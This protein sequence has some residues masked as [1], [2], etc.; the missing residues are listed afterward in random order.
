MPDLVERYAG[1]GLAPW[2]AGRSATALSM[3]VIGDRPTVPSDELFQRA[4]LAD[5]NVVKVALDTR[6]IEMPDG[7]VIE[8]IEVPDVVATMRTK[9][10]TYLG[11]VSPVY[12]VVQN[13]AMKVLGDAIMGDGAL[14][15]TAGSLLGGRVAWM[16][17][18]IDGQTV[19][20]KGDTSPTDIYFLIRT[21]HDA[22]HA[23][24]GCV[25]PI[26]TVCWN[27]MNAAMESASASIY[28]R[29]TSGIES[30][31]DELAKEAKRALGIIPKAVERFT[32]DMN[33]L[34]EKPMTID[35]FVAFTKVFLPV[36]PEVEKPVRIEA[37]QRQLLGVFE[38][39]KL[40]DGL[41]FTAYRAFNA[42]TEW[43]DHVKPYNDGTRMTGDDKRAV[44][45]TDGYAAQKK[46]SALALL[47]KA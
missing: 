35:E 33:R 42:V 7:R 9:D 13:E 21:G 8:P 29:H 44:S 4:G 25:S 22:R 31:I 17:F 40:L 2:W 1:T 36:N 43:T 26:R 16:T 24:G 10:G 45:I 14:G 37:Q 47:L 41:G 34:T 3:D 11:F 30:R 32:H 19:R 15:V 12:P 20:I 39:S 18:K 23:L 6:P 38:G 28:F 27:T 46:D 5:W